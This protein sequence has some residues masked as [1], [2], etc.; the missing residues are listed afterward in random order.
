[1]SSSW[2]PRSERRGGGALVRGGQRA[3]DESE[4]ERGAGETKSGLISQRT[5]RGAREESCYLFVGE[6]VI[7]AAPHVR[8]L[9]DG[10]SVSRLEA[11]GVSMKISF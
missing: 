1:M 4:D 3:V 8:R 7:D 5:R 2:T 6:F 9:V 11:S 10:P